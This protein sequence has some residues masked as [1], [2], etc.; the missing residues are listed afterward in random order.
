MQMVLAALVVAPAGCSLPARPIH[1]NNMMARANQRLNE[2]GK[3]F[4]KAVSPLGSG[5][6]ANLNEAKSAYNE[7]QSTLAEVKKEFDEVRPPIGSDAASTLLERYRDFLQAQQKIFDTC[8]TPMFQALQDNARYPDA[9]SKWAVIQP[10]QGKA[11]EVEKPAIFALGEAQKAY[12][13]QHKFE[14]K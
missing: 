9:A 6:A 3:K 13:D 2:S 8:Y 10:L 14:P 7:I 1:F 12:A 4:A 5:G 11:Q